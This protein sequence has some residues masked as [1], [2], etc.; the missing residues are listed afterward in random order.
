MLHIGSYLQK[1]QMEDLDYIEKDLS[2]YEMVSLSL[3]LF[4]VSRSSAS[5]ALQKLIIHFNSQFGT[6]IG[7]LRE[8]TTVNLDNWRGCVVEALA[9][10]DAKRVLRKL[11]FKWEE[12]R[13]YY[14]PNVAELSLQIHPLLKALYN[15]CERL[16]PEQ[17]GQLILNINE[18]HKKLE[19]HLRFY[20][21]EYLEIF[22][23]D[24]ITVNIIDIGDD[25]SE[26]VNIQV[27]LE[28]FIINDMDEIKTLLLQTI[29]SNANS[30]P[31]IENRGFYQKDSASAINTEKVSDIELLPKTNLDKCYVVE[32][33]QAGYILIINQK[34]FYK[35]ES[36]ELQHLLPKK[37]LLER[38]GTDTDKEKLREVFSSFGYIPMVFDNLSHIDLLHQIRETVKR[39]CTL[40]SI[41]ICILSHGISGC[42]YGCNSIP[43][44]IAEIEE[45]MTADA[46]QDKPKMLIL[47]A[48]Q[49]DERSNELS[50]K[51][52]NGVPS[53]IS[54]N[55][56]LDMI[57]AMSTVPGIFVKFI[58]NR[59]LI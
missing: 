59:N 43:I 30:T 32:R 31:T 14:L 17:A 20:D 34:N 47:Q 39:S 51:R 16:T 25:R 26:N 18:Q 49:R 23:L 36:K 7:L 15:M 21:F 45:I 41:I 33:N 58:D 19:N 13:E 5:F 44:K 22:L 29:R 12:I 4:G 50:D 42:I 52:K 37:K 3:L 53:N 40:S 9:I 2:F 55:A 54:P 24:W 1:I 48:C 28:F 6:V 57:K 11:G 8:Y 35:E 38:C 56:Y 10:I 46:L 27:L